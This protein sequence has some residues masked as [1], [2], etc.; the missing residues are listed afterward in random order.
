MEPKKGAGSDLPVVSRVVVRSGEILQLPDG[1]LVELL[2]ELNQDDCKIRS[3]DV[4]KVSVSGQK[5]FENSEN[6]DKLNKS[7]V[8]E[9][10]ITLRQ[11]CIVLPDTVDINEE[12]IGAEG[13]INRQSFPL[14]PIKKPKFGR[15]AK[16]VLIIVPR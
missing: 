8:W 7:G 9:H 4:D 1:Q 13:D 11:C 3:P 6:V 12:D 16:Y 14:Q 10:D 5:E 2:S 15:K